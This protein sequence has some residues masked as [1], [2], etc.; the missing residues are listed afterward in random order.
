MSV[1]LDLKKSKVELKDYIEINNRKYFVDGIKV[2]FE[3]SKKELHIALWL[4]KKLNKKIEL[5]PRIV[6]PKNIKTSDYLIDGEYW[7]LKDIISISKSKLTLRAAEKQ[8]N[9]IFQ[10]K[11]YKWLN[12]I[13]VKKNNEII[14]INKKS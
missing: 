9:D 6:L 1:K 3:P 10:L 4:S 13:V 2:I 8:L 5:L 7:D 11:G 12:K 14:I